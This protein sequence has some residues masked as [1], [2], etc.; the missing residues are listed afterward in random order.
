MTHHEIS[1][2]LD[3]GTVDVIVREDLE[4]KLKSGK[5]LRVKLGIDPTGH[6][7]TL[8]HSVGLRKL[9][10]F[11]NAGH[12]VVLL[13]GGFTA[14]IGDPSG[15]AEAR[16]PLT[17]EE[18][19]KNAANY[20][21]QAGKILDIKKCEIRNNRDWLAKLSFEELLKMAANFS[22]SRMMERDMFQERLKAGRAVMVHEFL[23]P[24]M[25]AYDSVILKADVEVGGTDQFFNLL[26][27]RPMQKLYGQPEQ[28]VLTWPILVGTDGHEKMSKSLNNYI[29]IMDTP[30]EMFGKIMSIPDKV[31]L[32]YF[33][34]LTDEN[35]DEVNHLIKSNPRDA[36]VHL[37]K[38]IVS[39]FHD[40]AMA[41]TAEQDFFQKFVKKEV[42]DEM[43]EFKVEKKEIGL[44]N[45][46]TQVAK[47]SPS[48]SDARRLVQEG[49][50]SLDGEKI[51]DPTMVVKVS[52]TPMVLKVGKR[53]FGRVSAMRKD[54]RT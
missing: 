17:Y 18:I 33:E 32:N 19:D 51:S 28:N 21:E 2:L 25:V 3:R 36:K 10:Q 9:K 13:F 4:K 45:L 23:Y 35:L 29:A 26:C 47:F 20:L 40:Q 1:E 54:G 34:L 46:I 49:G 39:N 43:P 12:T 5:K 24:L 52:G 41:K 11:Q 22:A 50:V 37:G 48:N 6:D 38:V 8:G 16:Q 27:G 7:L 44:L 15:K 30:Q 42:P 53:K 14:T 31:M